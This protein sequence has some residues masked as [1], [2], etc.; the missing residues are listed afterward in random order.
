MEAEAL[1]TFVLFLAAGVI[2]LMGLVILNIMKE[3]KESKEETRMLFSEMIQFIKL[4][5]QMHDDGKESN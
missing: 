4:M 2:V 1:L 3:N 5:R